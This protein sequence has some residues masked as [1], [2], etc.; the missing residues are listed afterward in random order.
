MQS[1]KNQML[2]AQTLNMPV[3]DFCTALNAFGPRLDEL[4]DEH[5]PGAR[6]SIIALSIFLA[7]LATEHHRGPN[8]PIEILCA[9]LRQ[10]GYL[11]DALIE[12]DDAAE[13]SH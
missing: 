2:L 3:K 1:I 12:A 5:F 6:S 8:D 7:K 9:T 11:V 10:T 13:E 4:I